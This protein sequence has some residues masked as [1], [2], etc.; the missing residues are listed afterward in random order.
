[1]RRSR[2]IFLLTAAIVFVTSLLGF[3]PERVVAQDGL[4]ILVAPVSV[5]EPLDRRFGERIAD[6]VRDALQIFAGYSALDV[7]DVEDALD[8][9]DLD[10]E[11]MSHIDW[12]QLAQVLGGSLVMVGTAQ[13]D[14]ELSLIHI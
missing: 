8:A 3:S 9:Y 12:R 6:E 13:Q 7:G 2:N 1:M 11:K 5:V 10:D 4:T 14:G